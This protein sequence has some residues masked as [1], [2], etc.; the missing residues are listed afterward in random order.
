VLACACAPWPG[1]GPGAGTGVSEFFGARVS[2]AFANVR[3]GNKGPNAVTARR[4]VETI[5]DADNR[6]TCLRQKVMEQA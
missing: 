6:T 5:N 2:S 3:L 4:P 1:L